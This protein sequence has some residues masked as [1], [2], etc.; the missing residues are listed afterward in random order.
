MGVHLFRGPT[1]MVVVIFGFS[2]Q[3]VRPQKETRVYMYDS[4]DD[5]YWG[6]MSTCSHLQLA[7]LLSLF[8]NLSQ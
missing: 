8:G 3:T 1:K 7:S 2:I 6:F 4:S 5:G